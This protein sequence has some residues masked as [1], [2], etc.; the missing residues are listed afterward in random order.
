MTMQ[1]SLALLKKLLKIVVMT[2]PK[3]SLR[4]ALTLY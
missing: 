3:K 1:P 4:P 2:I